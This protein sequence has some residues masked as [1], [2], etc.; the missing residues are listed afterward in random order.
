MKNTKYIALT[1]IILFLASTTISTL[2]LNSAQL[3]DPDWELVTSFTGSADKTTQT[4]TITSSEWRIYWSYIPDSQFPQYAVFA[5]FAYPKGETALFVDSVSADGNSETSSIEYV[6]E[7]AGQYYLKILSANLEAYSIHIQQRENSNTPTPTPT[8]KNASAP[9]TVDSA[10]IGLIIA[11]IVIVAIVG[12]VF[13]LKRKRQ[14][15]SQYPSPP[16]P[17]PT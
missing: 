14:P 11:V 8:V 12:L 15:T 9:L 16:P 13:A 1:I 6:Q 4:F 7:G 2:P 17:P 3:N 10:T 5:F